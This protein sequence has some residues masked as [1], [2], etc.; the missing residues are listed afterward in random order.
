MIANI[1]EE[2]SGAII[3][4]SVSILL[5]VLEEYFLSPIR[6]INKIKLDEVTQEE[7]SEV[8]NYILETLSQEYGVVSPTFEITNYKQ[9]ELNVVKYS[10]G[11]TLAFFCGEDNKVSLQFEV[12]VEE[13]CTFSDMIDCI[14]HEFQHYLDAISFETPQDW[15]AAYKNNV[16]YYE[17]K[18]NKFASKKSKKLVKNL[19]LDCLDAA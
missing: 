7:A 1:G 15:F 6:I 5:L 16:S 4:L 9:D 11:R 17:Y 10:N 3:F 13:A 8:C 2:M 12:L 18:A 19:M 14:S